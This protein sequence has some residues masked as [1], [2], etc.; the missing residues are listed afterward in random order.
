MRGNRLCKLLLTLLTVMLLAA[1]AGP[2]L[3]ADWGAGKN[4][5]VP[6]SA[7]PIEPKVY[8]VAGEAPSMAGG[9]VQYPGILNTGSKEAEIFGQ[10]QKNRVSSYQVFL[11]KAKWCAGRQ[12]HVPKGSVQFGDDGGPL[13]FIKATIGGQNCYGVLPN[14]E[15]GTPYVYCGSMPQGVDTYQTLCQ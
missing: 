7:I 14:N 15:G 13:Y 10:V 9:S 2:S 4:G 6:K 5:N 12:G 3:A 8:A 1:L 11:V